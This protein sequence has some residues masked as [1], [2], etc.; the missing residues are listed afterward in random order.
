M[1]DKLTKSEVT[2]STSSMV[3]ETSLAIV[4]RQGSQGITIV[5]PQRKIIFD[6]QADPY[7][8]KW[9]TES[10]KLADKDFETSEFHQDMLSCYLML[11]LVM[12]HITW[13]AMS[14]LELWQSYK[15]LRDDLVLPSATTLSNICRRVYA[16]T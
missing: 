5:S 12:A 15:A 7:W 10:S 4:K 2:E 8:T 11:G 6:I 14:N 3:D 16:P 13:N 9:Q 1:W